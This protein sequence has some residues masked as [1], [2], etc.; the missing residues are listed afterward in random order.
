MPSS[1]VFLDNNRLF[2]EH[3]HA[4][5]ASFQRIPAKHE[6]ENMCVRVLNF[7]AVVEHNTFAVTTTATSLDG[8]LRCYQKHLH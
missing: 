8:S 4:L 2:C 1:T 3:Q 6:N 7:P 5:L